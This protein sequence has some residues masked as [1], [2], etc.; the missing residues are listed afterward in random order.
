MSDP[1]WIAKRERWR[2]FHDTELGALYAA[3]RHTL[4]AYWQH[5]ADEHI[6]DKRLTTLDTAAR[7]AETAFVDKL[8]ELAG[9]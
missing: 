7:E 8:M 2:R 4:I 6:S 3:H 1:E 5:D 9:V